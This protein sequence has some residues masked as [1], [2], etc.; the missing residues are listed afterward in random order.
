MHPY[1]LYHWYANIFTMHPS[2]WITS[3][4]CKYICNSGGKHH[5]GQYFH[6]YL[7]G[8]SILKNQTESDRV[9]Q[10]LNNCQEKLDFTAIDEMETGM[11]GCVE[12][13]FFRMPLN[14]IR[15]TFIPRPYIF[16]PSLSL[17]H[18]SSNR[19]CSVRSESHI[20]ILSTC[21]LHE[22][23]RK[24]RLSLFYAVANQKPG[25]GVGEFWIKEKENEQICSYVTYFVTNCYWV[26]Y[27]F[28]K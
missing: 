16:M 8:L 11:V 20:M 26:R 23:R 4:I 6:G 17:H 13:I 27:C 7:A 3:L 22:S 19:F 9:I 12:S 2:I 18:T 10:C 1:E 21:L 14:P 25:H 24:Q 5:M 15:Q 28:R